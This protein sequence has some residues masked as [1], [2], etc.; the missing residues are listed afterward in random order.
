MKV[1]VK[2]VSAHPYD[3]RSGSS[4]EANGI[5]QNKFNRSSVAHK[6]RK[7]E[8]STQNKKLWYYNSIYLNI[9]LN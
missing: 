1:D 3:Y 9:N 4:E 5:K 2:I 8:V 6:Y 7:S